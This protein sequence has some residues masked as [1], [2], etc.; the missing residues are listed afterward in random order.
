MS[1]IKQLTVA[2]DFHSRNKNTME[3]VG[4]TVNCLVTDIL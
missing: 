3:G 4:Y 1:V 2:S